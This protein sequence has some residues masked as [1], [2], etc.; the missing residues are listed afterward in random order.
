MQWKITP[1]M[2]DESLATGKFFWSP[3]IASNTR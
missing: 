3:G 1:A 2:L